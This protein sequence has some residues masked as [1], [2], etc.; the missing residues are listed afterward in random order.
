MKDI[1]KLFRDAI[2]RLKERGHDTLYV[3][4]DAH[5]TMIKPSKQTVMM[6]AD[7]ADKPEEVECSCGVTQEYSFYTDGIE[8]LRRMTTCPDV[9]LILWTSTQNV[10]PLKMVCERYGIGFDYLNQNPDF[11]LTSYADFSKKF[12]FD[13][14]LDDKAGFE[15]LKDW[16]KLLEIDFD[17][18]LK[19]EDTPSEQ[20]SRG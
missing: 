12:Y 17:K 19:Q 20:V 7:G 18:E 10:T 4:V 5:G 1:R 9:K 11:Q 6:A 2:S 16:K 13:I 8:V 3:A 14:V 15:P